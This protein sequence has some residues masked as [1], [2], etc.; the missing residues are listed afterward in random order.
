M[1][2]LLR[3]SLGLPSRLP[4]FLSLIVMVVAIELSLVR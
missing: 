3:I 1:T 2:R 4:V